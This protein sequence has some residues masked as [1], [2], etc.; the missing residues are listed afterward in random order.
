MST[1][2]IVNFNDDKDTMLKNNHSTKNIQKNFASDLNLFCTYGAEAIL[3]KKT[4]GDNECVRINVV[5]HC[6]P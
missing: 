6:I 2:D 1:A 4:V 3:A 5:N